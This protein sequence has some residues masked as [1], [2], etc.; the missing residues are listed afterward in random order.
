L[1]SDGANPEKDCGDCAVSGTKLPEETMNQNNDISTE[2]TM[3]QSNEQNE[4][5]V[6]SNESDS[7]G[8]ESATD[9]PTLRKLS[10]GE[11]LVT[12]PQDQ[13]TICI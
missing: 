2:A 5:V 3:S 9:D 6:S 4:N 7:D 12:Q 11:I 10:K 1:K 13:E 8:Y